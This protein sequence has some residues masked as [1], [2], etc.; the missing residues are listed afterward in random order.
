MLCFKTNI[1][2]SSICNIFSFFPHIRVDGVYSNVWKEAENI[3]YAGRF[4]EF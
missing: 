2:P 4:S 1:Q 3:A